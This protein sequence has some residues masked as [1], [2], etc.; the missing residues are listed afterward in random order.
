[1]FKHICVV[2]VAL[3]IHISAFAEDV[4][5]LS[6]GQQYALASNIEVLEDPSGE[7][8]LNQVNNST[9]W[10]HLD[11]GSINFGFTSSAYWL[12]SSLQANSDSPW[13]LHLTYPLLDEVDIYSRINGQYIPIVNS[14]DLRPFNDRS[15]KALNPVV[16]YQLKAGD[17]L[18][19]IIRIATKG[20]LE[21]PLW[22]MS[23]DQYELEELKTTFFRGGFYG[24][25]IVMLLYN[26]F[27][28][29][30][31]RERSYLFYVFNV[32]AFLI[33]QTVYDGSGF[34]YFWPEYSIVNT[35]AFPFLYGILQI[36]ST[37]FMLEFLNIKSRRPG[38]RRYFK[39]LFYIVCLLPV[40]ALL[41][42]YRMVIPIEI[43]MSLIT[44]IS[45]LVLGIALSVRG[46]ISARYF[47]LAWFIF[48]VGMVMA[49][50]K[51]L[52]IL[53]SNIITQH[54]YQIGAFMEVVL[55]SLALAQRIDTAQKDRLRAQRELVKVHKQS[56]Q[57]LRRYEELYNDAVTGYFQ[58]NEQG[59]FIN[60]NP[61]YARIFGYDN[62]AEFLANV[63]STKALASN[64]DALMILAR[65]LKEKLGVLDYEI[66]A[67][68]KDLSLI[69]VSIS[70]K[71]SYGEMGQ[72]EYY[73]GSLLDITERKENQ[74]LR[75]QAITDRMAGMEQLVVGVSHEVN[76][77]LGNAYTS[78][79]HIQ[80]KLHQLQ[81]EFNESRVT[82]DGLER[83]IEDTMQSSELLLGSLGKVDSLIQNFK[84]ISVDQLGYTSKDCDV[85]CL[86]E[87]ALTAMRWKLS[88]Y[89]VTIECDK[90]LR[91]YSYPQGIQS[92]LKQILENSLVHGF[93]HKQGGTVDITV[94][95]DTGHKWVEILV[96]D[97][98]LGLAE[99]AQEKVFTPFYTTC[100]GSKGMLGLG[101]YQVYNIVTQLLRG[102]IQVVPAQQGLSLKI[103]LPLDIRQG[104]MP[105]EDIPS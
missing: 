81:E 77:P 29:I 19:I 73:E 43:L 98:G 79:S 68:R 21:A 7:L 59:E 74:Y 87:D 6:E 33:L 42:P 72:L 40:A 34:Q 71:A 47:T 36:A 31:L 75:E 1:M 63:D 51:G 23:K 27:I 37:L 20:T 57:N 89:P 3:L 55:L 83:T 25:L 94:S 99:G 92:V 65:L 54:A 53:P 38:A 49:N 13:T 41:L 66:E 102:Q 24:V 22:F 105:G 18:D 101:L 48:I 17:R 45:G 97:N 44:T 78:A 58:V 30:A 56:I 52:S 12:K 80:I 26:L 100:R 9:E 70:M 85:F 93:M 62:V 46:D 60:I 95:K 86:I 35:I 4:I 88:E 5:Q 90:D 16:H 8:D 2:V 96:A 67:Q 50:L 76:T 103:I 61:S 64:K 11:R 28:F 15:V 91:I 104:G 39:I 14:G 10:V 32:A 69:W 82:K 84:R